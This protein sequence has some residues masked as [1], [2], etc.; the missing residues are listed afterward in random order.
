MD[1]IGTSSEINLIGIIFFTITAGVIGNSCYTIFLAVDFLIYLG[2]TDDDDD[3]DDV[4][5][6]DDDDELLLRNG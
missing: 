1:D 3:E 4:D 6:D 5:D 2:L